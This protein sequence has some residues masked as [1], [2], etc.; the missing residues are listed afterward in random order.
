MTGNRIISSSIISSI[1]IVSIKR[2]WF[3]ITIVV[4]IIM[5]TILAWIRRCCKW[6]SGGRRILI[7]LVVL[8]TVVLLTKFFIVGSNAVLAKAVT[9]LAGE[10]LTAR[11]D[12]HGYGLLWYGIVMVSVAAG[13]KACIAGFEITLRGKRL[14]TWA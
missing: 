6:L 2:I 8:L 5:V 7:I 9:V 3:V 14:T 4:V 12:C 1:I 13:L 11:A 10:R